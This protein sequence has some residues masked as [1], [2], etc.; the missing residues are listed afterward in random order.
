M[1][2]SSKA[3]AIEAV[4]PE[5]TSLRAF[6]SGP[7]LSDRMELGVRRSAKIKPTLR[8]AKYWNSCSG[9]VCDSYSLEKYIAGLWHNSVSNIR[10]YL[11]TVFDK[12]TLSHDQPQWRKDE[13][14]RAKE[15]IAKVREL[16][17]DDMP[18]MFTPSQRV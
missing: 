14:A 4:I 17:R 15:V 7:G 1:S 18:D 12:L 11:F 5:D 9:Y 13:L 3:A 2:A 16:K 10:D 6:P 8:L